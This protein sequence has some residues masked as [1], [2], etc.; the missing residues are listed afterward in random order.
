MA[1]IE[2]AASSPTMRGGRSGLFRPSVVFAVIAVGYAVYTAVQPEPQAPPE[3]PGR[4][5]AAIV[6]EFSGVAN[7]SDGNT[8][9]IGERRIQLDGILTPSHG[10]RCG[11]VNVHRAAGD[12]L[13]EITR[14]QSV[15]CRISDLPTGGQDMAQC[16]VREGSL[17]EYMVANGWARDWPRHSGGA[18]AQ[19]EAEARAAGRGLWALSCPADLWSALD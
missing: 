15:V 18:Y 10:A 19:L 4:A 5:Q 13:R 1:E 8:L 17:N 11:D 14:R 12:A 6:S 7:V 2:L 3:E 9:R 16:S